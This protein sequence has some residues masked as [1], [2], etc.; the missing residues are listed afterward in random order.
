M[1]GS[2]NQARIAILAVVMSLLTACGGGGGGSSSAATPAGGIDLQI[3][4]FGDSLS[5]VGT[6]AP[7]QSRQQSHIRAKK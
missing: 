5:D 4:S 7:N 1:Q 2:N 3:V 6:Y